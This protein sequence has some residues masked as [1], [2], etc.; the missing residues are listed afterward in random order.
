MA[1]F[2]YAD[3]PLEALRREVAPRR[4]RRRVEWWL[5][6]GLP[7]IVL[8]LI[9]M[10]VVGGVLIGRGAVWFMDR[11]AALSVE[12]RFAGLVVVLVGCCVLAAKT[13]PEDNTEPPGF[14]VR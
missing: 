1:T 12:Q 14:D 6:L 13:N 5:V 11:I 2:D 3:E 9:G 8:V 7:A 10:W 4:E